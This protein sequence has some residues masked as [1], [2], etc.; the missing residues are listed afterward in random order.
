MKSC[1]RA[2]LYLRRKKTR[3]ALLF[4]LL[5]VLS[6]SLA[7][8]VTV[9]G[10]VGAAVRDVEHRL[11]TSFIVKTRDQ[12]PPGKLITAQLKDGNAVQRGV[13]PRADQELV[14]A[15][16]QQVDGITAYHTEYF[17]WVYSNTLELIEGGW[18]MDY[19]ADL[20]ALAADPNAR[21][22]SAN[23]LTIDDYAINAQTTTLYGNNDSEL[24]SYF[25]TGAFTLVDGRHIQPDDTGKVMVSDVLAEK[26]GVQL[27][28]TITIQLLG[29]MW[30]ARDDWAV[31]SELELEIVGLF[32]VNGY[33]PINPLV[34]E[35][36][37]CNNW[38][39]V[40]MNTSRTLRDAGNQNCYIDYEEPFYYNN[41]TFFV[42]DSDRLDEIIAEVESLDAVDTLYIEAIKDD[43]VYSATVAPL[44][45]IQYI[46][47]AV[48]L[49]ISAGCAVVLCIV[50]TMWIRSRRKE[51]AI[52][53]SLGFR[54]AK[55]L[56]QFIIEA[57]VVAAAASVIAFAVCQP[58]AD[59]IGNSMLSSAIAEAAPE[60]KVY[61]EEELYELAVGGDTTEE[62]ALDSG[63]YAGPEQIEFTFGFT[64]L[65]IL[66]GLELL[67]IIGAVCK[68]GSFI[69]N[70]TPRQILT[71][72]S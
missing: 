34:Y 16:M 9:W 38:F 26:N 37:I 67:V 10:S 70:M 59:A 12:F 49:A 23:G 71:T 45:M 43:T 4:L 8:G 68:S 28:D 47:L 60:E 25:R 42:E 32:H 2:L 24:F 52:Y 46:V 51:V 66:V 50:F 57:A 53:L 61:T 55:I 40:D 44:H 63:T 20:D 19:Q 64:E 65:L 72:L 29:N 62:F 18:G 22:G 56:G 33:Q 14:D 11:G 41:I 30:G 17:S 48:V 7:V 35:D 36:Y 27:G 5:F 69:F 58:I 1:K 6:L 39:L 54:K 31:W 3:T 13:I 15:I 21:T